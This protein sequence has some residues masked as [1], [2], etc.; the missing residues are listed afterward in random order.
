M[1]F[2]ED[3]NDI[4]YHRTFKRLKKYKAGEKLDD[5][6]TALMEDKKGTPYGLEWGEIVAEVSNMMNAGSDTAATAI[7]NAMYLL[8]KIAIAIAYLPEEIDSVLGD[9]HVGTAYD[10]VQSLIYFRACLDEAFRISPPSTFGLPRRTPEGINIFGD[11][12]PGNI[13]VSMSAYVARCDETFRSEQ[14]LKE[15]GMELEAYFITFSKGA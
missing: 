1:E 9:D 3:W 12:I 10:Q 14:W 7:N 15:G 13:S 5:F 2:N 6:F 4:V 8:L 11:F